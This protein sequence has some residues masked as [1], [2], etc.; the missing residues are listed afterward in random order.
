MADP[1]TGDGWHIWDVT[2]VGTWPAVWPPVLY[3]P[4]SDTRMALRAEAPANAGNLNGNIHGAFLAGLAEHVLGA[5]LR[6]REV[7]SVTV[8]MSVD[9]P[10]AAFIDRPLTG[11]LDIVR[12]TG[13]LQFVQV[14]F[15]QGGEVV[16][17]GM[18]TLRKIRS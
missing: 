16:I 6:M 18:G 8:S 17:H 1:L 9:Y 2:A 14:R 7:R 15:D 5:F 11:T 13:R 3:R 12:E 10:A 4:E